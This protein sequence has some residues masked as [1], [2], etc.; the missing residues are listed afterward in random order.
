VTRF[1]AR[2]QVQRRVY[3]ASTGEYGAPNK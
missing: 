2:A 1:S 3:D